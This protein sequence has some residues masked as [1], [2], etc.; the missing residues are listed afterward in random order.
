MNEKLENNEILNKKEKKRL[1]KL[2]KKLKEIKEKENEKI[3]KENEKMEKDNEKMEKENKRIENEINN[4]LEK[5]NEKLNEN[6]VLN[7]TS[8]DPIINK[9][10]LEKVNDNLIFKDKDESLPVVMPIKEEKEGLGPVVMP[11]KEENEELKPVVMPIKEDLSIIVPKKEEKYVLENKNAMHNNDSSVYRIKG[12]TEEMPTLKEINNLSSYPIKQPPENYF[13]QQP[14]YLIQNQLIGNTNNPY[15][16]QQYPNQQLQQP[17][18]S[19]F[20]PFGG[21][22]PL[23]GN[24]PQRNIFTPDYNGLQPWLMP[25]PN[26]SLG[27]LLAYNSLYRDYIDKNATPESK[28]LLETNPTIQDEFKRILQSGNNKL[29]TDFIDGI[30]KK[31]IKT[32]SVENIEMNDKIKLLEK[33]KE[34]EK[35][36]LENKQNQQNQQNDILLK[37]F[38]DIVDRLDKNKLENNYNPVI[39]SSQPPIYQ[40]PPITITNVNTNTNGGLGGNL[41]TEEEW[42]KKQK[43]QENKENENNKVTLCEKESL[44]NNQVTLCKTGDK[45][46][47]SLC[48]GD[49]VDANI[50]DGETRDI[51]LCDDTNINDYIK[52]CDDKENVKSKKNTKE[53]LINISQEVI[54]DDDYNYDNS[55]T[56]SKLINEIDKKSKSISK[57]KKDLPIKQLTV[58]EKK[59]KEVVINSQPE[60]KEFK[61]VGTNALL[62]SEKEF[63]EVGTNPAPN[64]EKVFKEVGTDIARDNF[65]IQPVLST[66]QQTISPVS[67]P[68]TTLPVSSPSTT[69]PVSSPSTTFP[70]SSPSTILP[71]SSPSTTFPVSSPSTT[72][73]VSSSSPI[74]S[75]SSPVIVFKPIITQNCGCD[76][77]KKELEIIDEKEN[78]K[79]LKIIK[80]KEDEEKEYKLIEEDEEKEDEEKED[81]EKEDEEKEDEEKEDEEKEDEEKEDEEKEDEDELIEEHEIEIFQ[82]C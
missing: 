47:V 68:S 19:Q 74:S 63:K 18:L 1:N 11:I 75:S 10:D 17:P 39:T 9:E 65:Y 42:K 29:I 40:M 77:I 67:S 8:I 16:Y 64:S 72:F 13:L 36:N 50:I 32:S 62:D 37:K 30:N 57:T 43:E 71:V 3:E 73:P 20:G 21:L 4:E 69:L 33:I 80:K 55:N 58:S 34:L 61:E 27:E 49:E 5:V 25:S 51:Q 7:K 28:I 41:L 24:Y 31:T 26:A 56:L 35:E 44:K 60:E 22:L 14:Q 66:K 78:S 76:N 15:G 54:E 59:D 45:N 53:D 12:M 38:N 6:D 52:N 79:K 70:V 46:Q 23:N 82:P 81:E 2:N 48:E